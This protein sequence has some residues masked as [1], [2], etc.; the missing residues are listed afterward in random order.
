MDYVFL[1]QNNYIDTLRTHSHGLYVHNKQAEKGNSNKMIWVQNW[2]LENASMLFY[3]DAASGMISKKFSPP[4][5]LSPSYF[6]KMFLEF[7]EF[8]PRTVWVHTDKLCTSA[9]LYLELRN[10]FIFSRT[11]PRITIFLRS[12]LQV[13][14][15]N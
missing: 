7:K 3:R 15:F 10:T 11:K 6:S 9:S 1:I 12:I 4:R 14:Y 2:E 8:P 5:S 13:Y